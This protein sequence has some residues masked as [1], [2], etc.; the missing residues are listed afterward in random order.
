M[1]AETVLA[2]MPAQVLDAAHAAGDKS[3][4]ALETIHGAS[5]PLCRAKDI[6]ACGAIQSAAESVALRSGS[7]PF[8]AE[9]HEEETAAQ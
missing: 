3:A 8:T 7:L 6:V 5:F 2:L 1:Q 4:L 9:K